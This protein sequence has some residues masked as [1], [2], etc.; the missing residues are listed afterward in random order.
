MAV[1][2]ALIS[3]YFKLYQIVVRPKS[4]APVTIITTGALQVNMQEGLRDLSDRS[5]LKKK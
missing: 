4:H 2:H 5:D 3:E 1:K